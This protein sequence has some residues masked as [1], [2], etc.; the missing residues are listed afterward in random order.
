MIRKA[1]FLRLS[2]N[3]C[4]SILCTYQGGVA[5]IGVDD[6]VPDC[7]Q[8]SDTAD[9]GVDVFGV[10]AAV[11]LGVLVVDLGNGVEGLVDVTNVVNH[12]TQSKWFLVIHIAE[13]ALDLRDVGAWRRDLLSFKEGGQVSESVK[14][15]CLTHVEVRVVLEGATI[16]KVGLVDEMPVALEAVPL[17]FDVI[18]K[19]SALGE[20]V[21]S[22]VLGQAWLWLLQVG[23]H[24]ES[25]GQSRGGAAWL[26]KDSLCSSWD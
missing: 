26:L 15:V 5:G 21:R 8:I 25:L 12:Q 11:T 24:V 10:A 6:R 18:S 7:V 13:G 4:Q 19:G 22:L 20:G 17:T 1:D 23:E 3:Y 14:Y 2:N 16:S 9:A